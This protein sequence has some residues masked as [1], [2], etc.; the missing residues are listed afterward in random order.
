MKIHLQRLLVLL[1]LTFKMQAQASPQLPDYIIYKKDTMQIYDLLVEKYI[2]QF[3]SEEEDKLTGGSFRNN[4]QLED[5]KLSTNCWRGYQAI[6]KVE[7]DSLFVVGVI[8]CNSI[9]DIVAKTSGENLRKVFGNK[10]KDGKVLVDWWDGA[11]SFPVA[12][13]KNEIVSWD[14]VSEY[15]FQYETLLRIKQ[16]KVVAA[17]QV[18]NYIDDLNSIN[19]KKEDQVARIILEKIRLYKWKR[20]GKFD[21]SNR[22]EIRINKSGVVDQVKMIKLPGLKISKHDLKEMQHC[23][24]ALAKVLKDLQFDVIK[25]KGVPVEEMVC[26]DLFFSLDGSIRSNVDSR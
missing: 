4:I 19:R 8:N 18:E 25:R 2:N 3:N 21:C 1:F 22:Y 6:Y 12:N 10:V 26:I 15:V 14:G 7:N 11:I 5:A 16:G 13:E 9:N 23:M 24:H 20:S 17:T